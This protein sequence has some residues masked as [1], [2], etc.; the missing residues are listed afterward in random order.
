LNGLKKNDNQLTLDGTRD[1]LAEENAAIDRRITKLV[2]IRQLRDDETLGDEF[3]K[4]AQILILCALPYSPTDET[5]ITR[6][7][8]LSDGTKLSVTFSAMREGVSMPFGADR[9]LLAWMFDSALREGSP[10]VKWKSALQYQKDTGKTKAGKNNR[11]L[12]ERFARLSGLGIVIERNG[13]ETGASLLV[14]EK[15]NLPSS[16][17]KHA[18]TRERVALTEGGKGYGFQLGSHLWEEIRKHHVVLPRQLWINSSKSWRIQD[19]S[20]WLYYR[21]YSAQS[22]SRVGWALLAEQFPPDKSNTWRLESLF[23]RAVKELRVIWPEAPVAVTKEGLV[24]TKAT[25]PLLPD[26]PSVNRVR[27]LK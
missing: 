20:L 22:T 18:E 23:E 19:A 15:W 7:C 1:Y 3:F 25:V 16:I 11:D 8:R 9:Q 10:I 12:K 2:S 26:N 4:L 24:F 21:C 27:K 5:K 6:R 13:G 17:D 14:I